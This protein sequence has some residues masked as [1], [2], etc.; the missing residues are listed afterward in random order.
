MDLSKEGQKLAI[1]Y[2]NEDGDGL[3]P[4]TVKI[5]GKGSLYDPTNEKVRT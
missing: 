2:F 4:I 1:E 5:V 3:Y